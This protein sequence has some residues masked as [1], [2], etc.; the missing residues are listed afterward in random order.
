M[1][2][3]VTPRD[4]SSVDTTKVTIKGDILDL[5]IV[6][7]TIDEAPALTSPVDA[8]FVFKDYVLTKNVNNIVYK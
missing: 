1:L 6:K 4:E 5:R 7:V 3:I 2:R 8:N